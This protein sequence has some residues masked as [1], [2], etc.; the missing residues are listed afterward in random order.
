MQSLNQKVLLNEKALEEGSAGK[1][2][3]HISWEVKGNGDV[4]N[5]LLSPGRKGNG[6]KRGR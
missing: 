3:T 5:L 6:G 4:V 2:G 1:E